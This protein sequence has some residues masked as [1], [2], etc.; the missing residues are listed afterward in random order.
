MSYE[1]VLGMAGLLM[2]ARIFTELVRAIVESNRVD[3]LHIQI[4]E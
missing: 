2:P 1:F 3:D 4:L